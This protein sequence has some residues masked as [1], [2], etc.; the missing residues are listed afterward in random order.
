MEPNVTSDADKE[1][2]SIG[3]QETITQYPKEESLV[4]GRSEYAKKDFW[5]ERFKS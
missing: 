3:H 2:L 1:P 4:F 5:N